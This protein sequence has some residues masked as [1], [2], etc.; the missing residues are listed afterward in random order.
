MPEEE[1]QKKELLSLLS[2]APAKASLVEKLAQDLQKS[3]HLVGELAPAVREYVEQVPAT[4]LTPEEWSHQI[5]GWRSFNEFAGMVATSVP[6]SVSF[7]AT[8]YATTSSSNTVVFVTSGVTQTPQ[9][10]SAEAKIKRIL[11]RAPLL[12]E[13]R[14]SMRRLG[15]DQR[16]VGERPALD[17]LEEAHASLGT[18]PTPALVTLRESIWAAISQ[19]NRRKP[20]QEAGSGS[21]MLTSIGRQ[22]GWSHLDASYCERLAVD[23]DILVKELSGGKQKAMSGQQVGELFDKALV[24]ANA[25]LSGIDKT[26][27]KPS[28]VA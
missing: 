28:S 23:W 26:R 4:S 24:F 10:L 2:E 11:H 17:L 22:C 20:K 16:S 14:A 9:M 12:E 25:L 21:D 1:S 6:P 27:L 8:S 13:A 15:L 5:K 3:A 18:G 19:L 7:S